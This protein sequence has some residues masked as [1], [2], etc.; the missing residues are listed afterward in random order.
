MADR[1]RVEGLA[2]FS[3]ALRK[4]DT[5]LPKAL[6]VALNDA[7]DI[8]VEG[9]RALV[10]RRTGKAAKSLRKAATRTLVRVSAGG[11]RAP[12]YAWLDFGGRVGRRDSVARRFYR[13]GRYI[14]PTYA[15]K[16]PD[17]QRAMSRAITGI[18]R[19]AGLEVT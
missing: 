8:V 14:Y 1:I 13:E 4:M 9:A 15:K 7:A 2:E 16:R 10:P 6:R 5:N 19:D 11:P 18:A 3:R 17:V 12:Y